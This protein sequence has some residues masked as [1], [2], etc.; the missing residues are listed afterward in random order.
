MPTLSNQLLNTAR[1]LP[2]YHLATPGYPEHQLLLP[3]KIIFYYRS[4]RENTQMFINDRFILF[5]QLSGCA[6]IEADQN[7]Y[8]LTPGKM[9]LIFPGTPHRTKPVKGSENHILQVAFNIPENSLPQLLFLKDVILSPD[10]QLRRLLL[11]MAEDFSVNWDKGNQRSRTLPYRLGEFIELLRNRYTN[12]SELKNTPDAP[13]KSSDNWKNEIIHRIANYCTCNLNRRISINELA[14]EL[15][16]SPSNLRLLFR[17]FT[18]HSL[19]RYLRNRR[20]KQATALLRSSA[21]NIKEI[22]E[23]CGYDSIASFCRAY[24]R[25]SGFTPQEIRKVISAHES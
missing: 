22:A 2:D 19:G 14:R 6:K 25:E 24:K 5:Y 13:G 4:R 15:K 9:L 17:K 11:K 21:L 1:A 23:R 10:L 18:G 12:L 8:V 16:Y 3:E 7:D 20:L